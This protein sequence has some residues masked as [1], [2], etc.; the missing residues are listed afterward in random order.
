VEAGKVTVLGPL[1]VRSRFGLARA[2]S[3]LT[4]NQLLRRNALTALPLRLPSGDLEMSA[5]SSARWE[6]V[7]AVL[8]AQCVVG[9]IWTLQ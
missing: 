1:G 4:S 7:V 3:L 5:G 6:W 8:L 9:Y 2:I